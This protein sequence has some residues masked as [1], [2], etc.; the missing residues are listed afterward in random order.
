MEL[1]ISY[2][3]NFQKKLSGKIYI[4]LKFQNK[5]ILLHSSKINA[6]PSFYR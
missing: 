2:V 6:K 3:Q 5:N 4:K 1:D